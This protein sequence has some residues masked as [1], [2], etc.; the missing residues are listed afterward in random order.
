MNVDSGT[1][2]NNYH[3]ILTGC[4]FIFGLNNNNKLSDKNVK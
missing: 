4:K 3:I 2:K 1:V